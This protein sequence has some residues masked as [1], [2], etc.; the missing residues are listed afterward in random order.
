MR[1]KRFIAVA[2]VTV[3]SLMAALDPEDVLGDGSVLKT[4]VRAGAGGKPR[5]GQVARLTYTLLL[6]DDTIVEENAERSITVGADGDG[7]DL[8][9]AEMRLGEK[10]R[11][12]VRFDRGFGEA[13]LGRRRIPPRATLFYD[14]VELKAVGE[15]PLSTD[16]PLALPAG[17]GD[18]PK[19]AVGGGPVAMEALGP[20]VINSDGTTAR[21]T[22]WPGMTPG[23]Q[24]NTRRVIV[25]RNAKR[26]AKLKAA[27]GRL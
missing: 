8:G 13:G 2:F 18:V 4:V 23:E 22:N 12:E 9:V 26:L 14:D 11:L 6:A 24:E 21:I 3:A 5:P 25:A 7:L 17:D 10:C 16:K 19:V 15:A 20:I 27:A 1:T